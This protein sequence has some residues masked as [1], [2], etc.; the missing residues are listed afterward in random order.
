MSDANGNIIPQRWVMPL[1]ATKFEQQ[2]IVN[3]LQMEVPH[4]N[5]H[6]AEKLKGW[7]NREVYCYVK[8]EMPDWTV[9]I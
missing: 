5:Q 8:Y 3:W 4:K 1:R 6:K 7:R 9:G 2:I